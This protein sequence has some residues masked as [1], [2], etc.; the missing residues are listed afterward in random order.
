MA[1][2][3]VNLDVV[4]ERSRPP[5]IQRLLDEASTLRDRHRAAREAVAVAQTELEQAQEADVAATAE[6]VRAGDAPGAM[7]AAIAKAACSCRTRSE[8]R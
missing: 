2:A 1:T 8:E 7:P 6:R 5:E 3:R 4:P